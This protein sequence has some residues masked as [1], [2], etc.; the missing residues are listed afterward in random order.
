MD[1]NMNVSNS[2]FKSTKILCQL[3]YSSN[4]ISSPTSKPSNGEIDVNEALLKFKEAKAAINQN[5]EN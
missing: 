5:E 3:K 4:P 1:Y 2:F